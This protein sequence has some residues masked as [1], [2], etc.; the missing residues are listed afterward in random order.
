MKRIGNTRLRILAYILNRH[1]EGRCPTH[2][3]I[4]THVGIYINAV[5]EHVSALALAGL[6]TWTFGTA[7]TLRPT[8]TFRRIP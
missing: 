5:H 2:R 7:R 1:Q 6:V 3:E 4:A 8:C